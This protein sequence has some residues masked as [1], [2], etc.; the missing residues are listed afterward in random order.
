L[1]GSYHQEEGTY[2]NAK[3]QYDFN[4]TF[5]FHEKTGIQG[6]YKKQILMPFGEYFPWDNYLPKIYEWI[7]AIN[8]FGR[9]E[10]NTLLLHPDPDGPAFVSLI[11]YE[12]LFD[13]L[14]DKFLKDAESEHPG[15]NLIL[16]NPTNDSWFGPTVEPFMHARLAQWQAARVQKPLVRATNTGISMAVAPWGEILREGP[17][18]KTD[19]IYSQLPVKK[20][21]YRI[22]QNED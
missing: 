2:N 15:R 11:C 21:Q 13:N 18:F 7:P 17:L 22:N 10:K 19:I 8:H 14:V 20:L 6:P 16:Y 9:G 3:T 1:I 12:I 4:I 5:L